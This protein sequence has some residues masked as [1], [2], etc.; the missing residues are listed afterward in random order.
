MVVI[1]MMC[2]RLFFQKCLLQH[3]GPDVKCQRSAALSGVCND[4]T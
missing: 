1:K 4:V 3:R 2:G